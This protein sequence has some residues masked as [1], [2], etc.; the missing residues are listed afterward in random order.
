LT[1]SGRRIDAEAPPLHAEIP[2]CYLTGFQITGTIFPTEGCWKV[3]AKAGKNELSFVTYVTAYSRTVPAQRC[4]TLADGVKS[5]DA[6]IVGRVTEVEDDDR[7]AWDSVAVLQNWKR[8][9]GWS[10]VGDRISLLQDLRVEPKLEA[11]KTYVLFMQ[12]DPW[13]LVCAQGTAIEVIGEQ[14]LSMGNSPLW[15]GDK[16]TDLGKEVDRL[17]TVP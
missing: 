9:P 4:D 11:K 5:S 10:G 3:M 2:C 12:F 8:P 6:I 15:T 16:L 7:Y 13:R 1:I 17:T 14:A